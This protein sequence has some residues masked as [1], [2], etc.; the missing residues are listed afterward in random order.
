MDRP[1]PP[2]DALSRRSDEPSENSA[3][4]PILSRFPVRLATFETLN[5]P[6]KHCDKIVKLASIGFFFIGLRDRVRCFQCGLGLMQWEPGDDPREAHR[7][8]GNKCDYLDKFLKL[9][10]CVYHAKDARSALSQEPCDPADCE[11][12]R[13]ECEEKNHL[14]L[15]TGDD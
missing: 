13:W 7:S 1:T 2:T 15:N 14:P 10:P 8:F 9:E 5:W 12:C 3:V 6:S 4:Y 11:F